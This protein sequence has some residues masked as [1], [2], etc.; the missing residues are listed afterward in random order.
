[1]NCV[2]CN[3][4]AHAVC[5][6]CGRAVCKDHLKTKPYIVSLYQ[7]KDGIQKAVIVSDA[8]FCGLC[9]PHERPVPLPELE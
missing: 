3:R 1:M 5:R 7:G 6:F 2:H 4:T 9:K 8:I